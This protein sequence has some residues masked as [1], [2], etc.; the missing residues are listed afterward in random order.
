MPRGLTAMG[1]FLMFGACMAMLAG[2]TLTWPGT[3]LDRVWVLNPR[4]YSLLASTGKPVGL[5]FLCLSIA[6][7]FAATGWLKRR[8]WGW[9]LAVAIIGT[10]VLGDFAS[11]FLGRTVEGA[12]GVTVA[13]ALLY[14]IARRRV[15]DAFAVNPKQIVPTRDP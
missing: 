8:Q 2:I 13:G 10:Q 1:I 4:A 7:A 12:V 6:L 9:Q 15:R 3:P 14:Y 5:L 11:I